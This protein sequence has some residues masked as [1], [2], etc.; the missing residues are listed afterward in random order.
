MSH[1][2]AGAG[3]LLCEDFEATTPGETPGAP[4]SLAVNGQAGTVSVDDVIPAHGG[5]HSLRV[6]S[7]GNYQT[8]L[9]L[10]GAPVFP[11]PNP[12][13]YV[14]VHLRLAE[15]MTTGHNTYFKAGAA[16]AI[17][18]NNETRVGVMMEML[19][20]NQPEGDRGF[21]S[22]ES[23]W[24]DQQLGAVVPAQT[25]TCLEGFFDPPNST[26]TI[27]MNDEEVAD[28]HRTDWQQDPLGA[29]HFGFEQYAGP[30]TDVWY[31]DIVVSTERIGC[32]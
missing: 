10:R 21:L 13:L 5:A 24:T 15:P 4:W 6:S 30:A 26:V 2:C 17:S 29:L 11:A 12:A 20:I 19:M 8:F 23:Y 27:W 14:R 31:D 7:G 18:S 16:D 3:V 9:A 22:N 25:W 32:D 1:G 28:L